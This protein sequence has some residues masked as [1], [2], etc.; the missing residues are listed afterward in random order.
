MRR[1]AAR[2]FGRSV[3]TGAVRVDVGAGAGRYTGDLG[4]PAIALDAARAM[5]DLLRSAAPDAA[6]VQADVEALPLRTG[7]VGGAW[8]NMTYHHIPRVRLPMALADLH[9]AL[10]VGAPVD[11]QVAHGDHEGP[12]LPGDDVG[13]RFFA[14]WREPMLV[15]VVTGAGFAV[16]RSEVDAD[17]VR[18]RA[19]REN[20]LADTVGPGMRLLVCGLNPSVY[21]AERGVGY[22]RPGNR[23]WK[24][25]VA[26]GLV[27]PERAHDP[28][29]VLRHD[30]LGITDL[31]KRATVA[32]AELAAEEYRAG[33]ERVAQLVEWLEPRAVAFVGL[34]GWRAA[35][36]RKS[37]AGLQPEPFG[38]RPAY[39]LPSTSGL[40]A[41][42]RIE[43]LIGHFRAVADLTCS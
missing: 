36:D 10:H 31:V 39:V 4:T 9:R 28:W 30:G 29:N 21:S 11:L 16:E 38:G 14:T 13:G 3:A 1:D 12:D 8:S 19:R 27:A 37:K 35:V 43:D 18:V 15:D 25:I 2:A 24:A 7:S 41:H 6:A 34:E 17:V 40:N 5:L 26:S 33:A 32:S 42:S 23:F 22:A 20:T